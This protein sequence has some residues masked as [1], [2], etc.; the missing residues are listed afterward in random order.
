MI[1]IV[2]GAYKEDYE[3]TLPPH[4]YINVDDFKSIRELTDY[5]HYLDKNDTAYAGYLAWKEYGSIYVSYQLFDS[6][7]SN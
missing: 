5:L 4:S 6:L 1:P 2:M 3:S 7:M